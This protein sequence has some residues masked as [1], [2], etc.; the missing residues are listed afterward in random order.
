MSALLPR[1]H[2]TSQR[3]PNYPSLGFLSALL[4]LE[5]FRTVEQPSLSYSY[6]A[7][8]LDSHTKVNVVHE[9]VL[10]TAS[11]CPSYSQE[12]SADLLPLWATRCL[13]R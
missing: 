11:M 2:L 13:C 6:S 7:G 5:T 3:H 8:D 1:S 12:C 9:P 10:Q 4:G